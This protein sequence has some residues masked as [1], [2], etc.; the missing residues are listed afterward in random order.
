[1]QQ[2]TKKRGEGGGEVVQWV[3]VKPTVPGWSTN[4]DNKRARPTMLAVGVGGG[5]AG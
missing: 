4:L 3:L 5:C 1:M 2:I